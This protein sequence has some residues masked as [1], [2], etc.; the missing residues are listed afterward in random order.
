MASRAYLVAAVLIASAVA[1]AAQ[2]PSLDYSQW[3]GQQRDGS[4][5]GF[6]EPKTW[7]AALTRRWKVEV[8]EGYA[9][10]LVIGDRVYVFTRRDGEEGLIALDASTGRERWR[11]FYDAPYSPAKPAALHGAGPKATPL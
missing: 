3:R 11:S 1:L 7:P 5:S 4:A 2:R 8:G 9:T 10:P 6:V